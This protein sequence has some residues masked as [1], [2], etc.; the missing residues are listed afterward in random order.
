M[1]HQ[2]SQPYPRGRAVTPSDTLGFS[3][4]FDLSMPAASRSTCSMLYVGGAGNV[5]ARFENGDQIT[6][7]ATAGSYHNL[8][9]AQIMATNTTATG[10]IAYFEYP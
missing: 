5:V 2:F 7:A 8:R 4:T 3:G 9:L 10:L 1:P 6:I